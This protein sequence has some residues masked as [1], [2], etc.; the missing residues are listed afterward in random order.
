MAELVKSMVLFF[1]SKIY[2]PDGY[3]NRSVESIRSGCD[4]FERNPSS[5]SCPYSLN[6]YFPTN[7]ILTPVHNVGDKGMN[8][9]AT[10]LRSLQ[11]H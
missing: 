5:S 10:L 2:D 11:T 4:L 1:L 9:G 8:E 7:H 3:N 6:S